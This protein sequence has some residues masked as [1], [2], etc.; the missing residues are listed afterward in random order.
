MG[1]GMGNGA[2]A[3]PVDPSKSISGI[4]QLAPSLKGSVGPSDVLFLSVRQDQGGMPG[5]IL[6]VDRLPAKDFPVAFH[7]DGSKA[8]SP[9]TEFSGKAIVIAR[10][11]KDGDA[12]THNP[13]DLEGKTTAVV[14]AKHIVVTI[15][16]VI[17]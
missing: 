17:Q 9:G 11:D 10:V 5:S 15:D 13:G 4:V 8:M 7:I 1:A 14:P 16:K 6:A 12:M 2:P 3:A